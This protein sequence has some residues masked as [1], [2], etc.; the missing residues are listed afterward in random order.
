MVEWFRRYHANTIRH[1]GSTANGQSES[2]PPTPPYLH[3]YNDK[4]HFMFQ[5]GGGVKLNEPGHDMQ[6]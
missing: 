6:K 1:M 5:K 4:C 2:N 3:G